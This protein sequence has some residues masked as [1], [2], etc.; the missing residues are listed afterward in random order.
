[1]LYET[2][3]F[4]VWINFQIFLSDKYWKK[5]YSLFKEKVGLL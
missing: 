2:I 3:K 5:L 4:N 1:M